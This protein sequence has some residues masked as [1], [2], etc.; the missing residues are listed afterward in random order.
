MRKWF[1]HHCSK[2]DAWT[3]SRAQ[4]GD[5]DVILG[6]ADCPDERTAKAVLE[7]MRLRDEQVSSSKDE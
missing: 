4:A 5:P 6:V 7:A 1:I 2:E 3:V